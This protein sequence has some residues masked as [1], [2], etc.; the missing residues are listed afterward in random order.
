MSTTTKGTLL[1]Y[2]RI[3]MAEGAW[4]SVAYHDA[5]QRQALKVRPCIDYRLHHPLTVSSSTQQT[6]VPTSS[7][8]EPLP[9]LDQVVPLPDESMPE[10]TPPPQAGIVPFPA[11]DSTG[12]FPA[13]FQEPPATAH[14]V[15]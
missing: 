8:V 5:A 6:I 3:Y 9:P 11:V 7:L 1:D 14:Y 10:L 4:P 15:R 2:Y 13:S 12:T